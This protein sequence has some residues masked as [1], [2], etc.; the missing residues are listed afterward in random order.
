MHVHA[1]ASPV[2]VIPMT[3]LAPIH[4][5]LASWPIVQ[6]LRDRG[7]AHVHALL[8]RGHAHVAPLASSTHH[9]ASANLM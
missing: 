6:A 4:V 8:D 3:R 9:S 7:H 2:Q 1:R 5:F